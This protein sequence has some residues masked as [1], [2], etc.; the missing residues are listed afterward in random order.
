[1]T[2]INTKGPMPLSQKY[3]D[4]INATNVFVEFLEGTTSSGKTTIGAGVKFMRMVSANPKKFHVIA[5]ETVGKAEATIIN[6]T[7]GILDIHSNATYYGNGT[8][9]QKIPH[10]DFEGQTIFVLPYGDAARWKMI[11]GAQFGCVYIDEINI[12]NIE[13]LRE[14]ITRCDYLLA[15]CNPDDPNKPVYKEFIN[16]SRPFKKYTQDVPPSILEELVEP[17]VPGWKYWFFSFEDNAS[18]TPET[19]MKKKMASPPGTKNHKNKILG[20][21]GRSEGL[22]FQ[23]F[24]AKEHCISK[25]ELL[26]KIEKKEVVFKKFSAGLDTSYSTKTKDMISMVFIGITTDGVCY[27]LD[28]MAHNNK[29]DEIWGPSDTVQKYIEFVEKNRKEW[30]EIR[31]IWYDCADAGFQAEW[32]KY[33]RKHGTLYKMNGSWKIPLR[34]RIDL[35][36]EWLTQGYFYVVDSCS[37]YIEEMNSY[38]WSDKDGVPEDANDHNINACQYAF[39]PNIPMIGQ[40]HK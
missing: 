7:N 21:R 1:M 30:G 18:M 22:V 25:R 5:A 32:I 27:V 24:N 34:E 16:R 10:I 26:K 13:F 33:K 40:N 11:L 12:A 2:K 4:F 9:N 14:I 8:K 31:S 19:I 3:I 17:A 15:T 20:L 39:I 29:I 23:V 35:Q 37:S 36:S 38:S 6:Q 28:N